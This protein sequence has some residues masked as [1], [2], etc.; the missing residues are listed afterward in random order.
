MHGGFAK[1]THAMSSIYDSVTEKIKWLQALVLPDAEKGRKVQLIID[2]LKTDHA[3]NYVLAGTRL[4]RRDRSRLRDAQRKKQ[5][6]AGLVGVP[7]DRSNGG[8]AARYPKRSWASRIPERRES[9]VHEDSHDP[10]A[11]MLMEIDALFHRDTEAGL[12]D[13]ASAIPVDVDSE[14]PCSGGHVECIRLFRSI[15][16]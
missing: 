5:H 9:E 7:H 16:L 15:S 1:S 12:L 14:T 10:A 3:S 8:H 4:D 6:P 11:Q 2:S 13:Q